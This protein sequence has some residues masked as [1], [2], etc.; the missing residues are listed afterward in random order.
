MMATDNVLGT[1][2]IKENVTREMVDDI[3]GT[4]FD[5]GISYWCDSI[6]VMSD[7]YPDGATYGSDCLSRGV[8]IKLHVWDEDVWYDLT[9]ENFIKG[10]PKACDNF[11]KNLEQFYEDHDA[12]YADV[13]VQFALFGKVVYG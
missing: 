4:A 12:M 11:G 6:K 10:L 2:T 8:T 1:I 3:V 9:L 7:P 5:S 13:A